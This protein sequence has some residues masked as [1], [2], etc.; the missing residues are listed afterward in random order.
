MRTTQVYRKT[1]ILV[2][3]GPSVSD[4]DK[5]RALINEG[6]D[7]FRFNFSHGGIEAHL[8]ILNKV[9]KVAEE[10]GKYVACLADLQGPKIRVGEIEE[11]PLE[12]KEGQHVAL[13]YCER[14]KPNYEGPTIPI[15][16]EHILEDIHKDEVIFLSDGQIELQIKRKTETYLEAQS[17]VDGALWSRK[18]VNIPS[19]ELSVDALTEKDRTHLRAVVQEDFDYVALSFVR[20][21]R[22]LKPARKIIKKSNEDIDLIAK[23][24]SRKALDHL[25]EIIESVE[26]IIVARGDLGVEIGVERVPYYQKR[27]IEKAN[28]RGKV[29]ITA[30]QMLESMIHNPGPTRAEVS[31]VSNAIL[32]G[33]DVVMLSGETAVGE[34]PIRSVKTMCDI[35][36]AT[37]EDFQ[38]H[39]MELTPDIEHGEEKLAASMSN[40]AARVANEIGASAII[41]PTASGYTA[42]MVSNTYPVCPIIALSFNPTSRQKAALYRNV[43]PYSLKKIEDTDSLV[44]NSVQ[45]A[46]ELG[47][48]E[49]GDRVVLLTGLPTSRTGV[50]NL[51]HV[52]DVD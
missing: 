26:G 3:V 11:E 17:L 25:D 18:G 39:L 7:G 47:Y 33:S 9:R 52:I 15:C 41:A 16:Y 36:G 21:P 37:E 27:M 31:D 29:A 24:E 42:R 44:R 4:E 49:P 5:I 10:K 38:Q 45:V 32:D 48:A 12:I 2:T 40:A 51:L 43:T 28:R 34:H 14:E 20:H 22:D 30:T 8:P 23:L 50:T 13:Y 1:K 19:S 46:K 6:V 35:I